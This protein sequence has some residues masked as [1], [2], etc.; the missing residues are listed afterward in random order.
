MEGWKFSLMTGKGPVF[1][2]RW[3]SPGLLAV[4]FIPILALFMSHGVAVA[5]EADKKEWHFTVRPYLWLPNFHSTF[6]FDI[7]SGGSGSPNVEVGPVDFLEHLQIA[8]MIGGEARKNRWSIFTDLIFI[9]FSLDE[10]TVRS[11]QFAGSDP[12]PVE[13]DADLDAGT[14]SSLGGIEWTLTGGYNLVQTRDTLLH[15]FGGFRLLSVEATTDWSLTAVVNGPNSQVFN[16][17]GSISQS[18]ELWDNIVGAR[19]RLHLGEGNWY[20]PYYLDM[21]AGSSDLTWQGRLGVSYAYEWCEIYLAYRYLH[22]D[23]NESK[24][25]DDMSINGSALGVAFRF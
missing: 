12:D 23:T 9:N 25:I 1:K 7:P 13:I 3:L 2:L 10:S 15:L 22:Y 24:L 17:S 6:N 20:L 11:V 21:G 14:R 18:I 5:A 8:G 4:A 16:Q 19:G